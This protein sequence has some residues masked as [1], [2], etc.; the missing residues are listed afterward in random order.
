VKANGHNV[1]SA[2]LGC[3]G[4]L[5]AKVLGDGGKIGGVIITHRGNLGKNFTQQGQVGANA[6][7][8]AQIGRESGKKEMGK[9]SRQGYSTCKC[10]RSCCLILAHR[11]I[12]EQ[13]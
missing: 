10:R 9:V 11:G 13:R 7:N 4:S 12:C 8:S 3:V 1:L 5:L 6:S 2:R